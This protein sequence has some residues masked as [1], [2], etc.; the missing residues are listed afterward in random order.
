MLNLYCKMAYYEMKAR[1]AIQ[2]TLHEQ[3]GVDGLIVALILVGVAL[4]I[5]FAF[6]KSLKAMIEN[7]WNSL[8]KNGNIDTTQSS[9]VSEWEWGG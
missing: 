1:R 2:R 8:V 3:S 4:I 5:G 9:V 6:R 7:L